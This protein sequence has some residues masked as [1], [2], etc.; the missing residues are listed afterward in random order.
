VAVTRIV[1]HIDRLVLRGF[2]PI[3]RDS[4]AEGLRQELVELLTRPASAP[5]ITGLRSAPRL[6]AGTV[7]IDHDAQPAYIGKL[8]AGR[9][10]KGVRR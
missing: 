9:I 4:L 7:R 8:I 5:S 6:S 10:I 3:D 1:L 2:D